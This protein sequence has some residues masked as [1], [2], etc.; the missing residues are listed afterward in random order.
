MDQR[1]LK[2]SYSFEGKGLHTGHYSHMTIKPAGTGEGIRF[3]RTDLPEGENTVAALA[4]NITD[5]SRSTKIAQGEASVQT[6]EHIMSALTGMGIDN[7]VIET[8]C[9]EVPILDGS[10]SY[11]VKAISSDGTVEQDAERKYISVPEPIE[12]KDDK[13][14]AWVKIEPADR[15]S[16]DITVDF[17]SHVLGV[18][19]AHWDESVDYASQIGI[20]RTFVFFHE[21]QYLLANNLIKGGDV[22]N[23]IVVCEYPVK[24]E[25]LEQMAKLFNHP[26]VRVREDGYLTNLELH[27]PNECGR[28]KLLDLIG[29]V[30]LCGGFLNAKVTA[31]KP[32]HTINSFAT[33]AF[34]KALGHE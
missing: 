19:K 23:A 7:A 6:I 17:G 14:G 28:H 9:P 3:V 31:F 12:V 34:R 13:S 8:D 1:T 30:R 22:D 18:Q 32:G 29:D 33:K 2:N 20:C 11:Y 25:V 27:F 15:L 16:F 26:D 5:T 10:A 21:I 4:E 24:E